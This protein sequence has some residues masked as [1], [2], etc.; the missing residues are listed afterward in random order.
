M[1]RLTAINVAFCNM[2]EVE[3]EDDLIALWWAGPGCFT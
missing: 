3:V 1:E 2:N